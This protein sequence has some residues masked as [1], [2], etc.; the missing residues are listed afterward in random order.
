MDV[1]SGLLEERTT[2]ENTVKHTIC[3]M[4]EEESTDAEVEL[5]DVELAAFKRVAMALNERASEIG[6]WMQ[7]DGKWDW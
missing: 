1:E 4:S 7:I 6:P 3:L 5:N 2:R